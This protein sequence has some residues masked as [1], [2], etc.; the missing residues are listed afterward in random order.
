MF[1]G[2]RG[3]LHA[4][5][6]FRDSA[7]VIMGCDDVSHELVVGSELIEG[8]VSERRQVI[9]VVPDEVE[10]APWAH[11]KRWPSPCR[12]LEWYDAIV[13]SHGGGQERERQL[14]ELGRMQRAPARPRPATSTYRT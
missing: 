8:S 13:G 5:R 7:L 14:E 9:K 2:T 6:T 11:R 3:C 4:R 10:M 12:G 1:L